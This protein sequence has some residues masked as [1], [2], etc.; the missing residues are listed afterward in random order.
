MAVFG[1]LLA[2]RAASGDGSGVDRSTVLVRVEQT[3]RPA[4]PAL[5][6]SKRLWPQVW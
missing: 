4:E 3:E 1:G 2:A 5:S 6:L